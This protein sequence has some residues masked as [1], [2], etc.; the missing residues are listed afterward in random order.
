MFLFAQPSGEVPATSTTPSTASTPTVGAAPASAP[1][2]P[3]RMVGMSEQPVAP[4]T[5]AGTQA[6]GSPGATGGPGAPAQP[7][8][9]LASMMP[10]LLIGG[11]FIV[12]IIFSSRAGAKERKRRAEML[13]SLSTSDRVQT[14]GGIIGV[15][16]EIK[17]DEVTLRVDEASNTRIRF[18]KGAVSSVLRKANQPGGAVS[19][20]A[21][22]KPAGNKA[23]V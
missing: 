1:T 22:A 20:T 5:A 3:T 9:P 7:V 14:V 8:S 11:L 18:S 19:S 10:L 6:P 17:D 13:S 16:T 21:E 2:P 12:M 15:V 4:G 23:M